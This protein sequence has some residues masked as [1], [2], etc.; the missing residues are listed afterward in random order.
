MNLN[1]ALEDMERILGIHF[2]D[3]GLL[4]QGLAHSSF[5]NEQPEVVESS[6]ERLE[7]L[8]DAFLGYVV[9]QELFQRYPGMPEGDLTTARASLVSRHALYL[10][11]DRLGLGAF[12]L[13]GQGEEYTGGRRRASNLAALVE[14]LVGAV[15]EDQGPQLAKKV[16]LSLLE[17][18]FRRLASQGIVLDAKSQLHMMAQRTLGVPPVYRVVGESGPDR[19]NRKQFSVEVVVGSKIMGRGVGTKKADAEQAA[20]N[21]AIEGFSNLQHLTGQA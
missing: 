5:A 1:K 10:V 14:S 17:P 16:A 13:L 15:L 12:L 20:A 7:F 21:Q 8:G 4:I 3:A 18:D 9:A 6:N 19:A 2:N 11:A